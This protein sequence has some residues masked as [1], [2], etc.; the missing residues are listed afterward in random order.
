MEGW[1]NGRM[2]LGERRGGDIGKKTYST[3]PGKIGNRKKRKSKLNLAKWAVMVL[4]T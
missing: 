2:G 1:I 3:N 4:S